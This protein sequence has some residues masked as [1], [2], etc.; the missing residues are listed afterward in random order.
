MINPIEHSRTREEARKYKVEPYVIPGDVYSS[1]NL[2]GRGGWTW[3]TGSSGWFYK[4]GVEH[5][6]GLRIDNGYIKL[7][8]CIPQDWKE[9][10]IKYRY[11]TSIYNI[12]VKNPNSKQQGVSEFILNGKELEN[13]K[14]KLIDDGSINEIEVI[15]WFDC[16]LNIPNKNN[17]KFVK[18][19]VQKV[20]LWYKIM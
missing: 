3:Y 10:S 15:M 16:N 9:Y 1:E 13:K 14:I 5:I 11:K 20:L 4:A 7:E 18:K 6:L 8:P 19:L 17:R 12:K 2:A